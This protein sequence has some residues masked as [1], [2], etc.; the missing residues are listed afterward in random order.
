MKVNAELFLLTYGAIV[1]QIIEDKK[2]IKEANETLLKYGMAIGNRLVDDF[3]SKTDLETGVTGKPEAITQAIAKAGFKAYL[4]LTA[5]AKF[6][7]GDEM[8]DGIEPSREH[9]DRAIIEFPGKADRGKMCPVSAFV[10]IPEHLRGLQYWGI[11]VG[12]M[13]GALKM[14]DIPVEIEVTKD[15]CVGDTKT[16]FT[17]YFDKMLTHTYE[18][19]KIE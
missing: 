9:K 8:E 17:I 2:D 15:S 7:K 1:A 4:G 11:I 5:D 6:I 19:R 10:D 3:L 14:L 12:V 18:G 16:E 13:K